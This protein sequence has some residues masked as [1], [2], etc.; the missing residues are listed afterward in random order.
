MVTSYSRVSPFRV[1]RPVLESRLG[2]RAYRCFQS[3]DRP[4]PADGGD[5]LMGGLS[6]VERNPVMK[7]RHTQRMKL[8]PNSPC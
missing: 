4:G 3:G 7:R 2:S 8:D 1:K 6:H 5:G